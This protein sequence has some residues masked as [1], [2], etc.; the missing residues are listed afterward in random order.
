MYVIV[1]YCRNLVWQN[2]KLLD[3]K[4]LSMQRMKKIYTCIVKRDNKMHEK[5]LVITLKK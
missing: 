1:N 3:N 4:I 2:D 5:M